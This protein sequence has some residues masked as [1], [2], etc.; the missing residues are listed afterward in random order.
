MQRRIL[1]LIPCHT[2]PALHLCSALFVS[3]KQDIQPDLP[4]TLC[5]LHGLMKSSD[6]L[7]ILC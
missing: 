7:Y 3:A 6:S 2:A 1:L 4:A 5:S